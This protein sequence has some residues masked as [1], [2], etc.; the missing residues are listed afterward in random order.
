MAENK[1]DM[2]SIFN[3]S[4]DWSEKS[5]LNI[6]NIPL[7]NVNIIM[8]A[9]IRSIILNFNDFITLSFNGMSCEPSMNNDMDI[10]PGIVDSKLAIVYAI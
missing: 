3:N 7:P 10:A 6:N 1:H 8:I 4:N 5:L 9:G 2:A